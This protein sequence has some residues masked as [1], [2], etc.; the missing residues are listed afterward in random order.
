MQQKTGLMVKILLNRYDRNY[1]KNLFQPLVSEDKDELTQINT[2]LSNPEKSFEPAEEMLRNIHYS[3]LI[4]VLTAIPKPQQLL[5][6]A[7]LTKPQAE[8][9]KRQ[10]NHSHPEHPLT[11]LTEVFLL[12]RLYKLV[13]PKEVLPRSFLPRSQLDDL[14]KLNKAQLVNIID[15]LG[16]YDLAEEVRFIINKEQVN[17][18]HNCLTPKQKQFLKLSLHQKEKLVATPLDLKKWDGDCK[19]LA[20]VLHQRGLIRMGKALCGQHPDAL[21]YLT[22]TLDKG[23]GEIL[24]RHYIPTPISGV[25]SALIQQVLTL[26]NFLNLKSSK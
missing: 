10:F 4:P 21:W 13:K 3:W 22:H 16:I 12:D 7:A 6:L 11:K 24:N 15:L 20:L 23:R 25:T 17:K 18:I 1:A 8:K 14:F 5:T 19:T 9:M 26:I 2:T